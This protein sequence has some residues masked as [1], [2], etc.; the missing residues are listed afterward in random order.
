MPG[1]SAS[2]RPGW[3]LALPGGPH[4]AFTLIEMLVV[5]GILML[6]MGLTLG[7]MNTRRTD[8]LVAAEQL[9]AD[10]VRQGRHTARTSGAPVLL[11]IDQNERTIAG[12]MRTPAWGTT[13]DGGTSLGDN[14]DGYAGRGLMIETATDAL[15]EPI[16]ERQN[17]FG[18]PST[19]GFYL[20]CAVRPPTQGGGYLPL[21]TVTRDDSME[22]SIGGLLMRAVNPR[23]Q[24]YSLGNPN[25]QMQEDPNN[26][27]VSVGA[28]TIAQYELLGWLGDGTDEPLLVSNLDRATRPADLPDTTTESHITVPPDPLNPLSGWD[29]AQPLIGGQ[30][31]QVGLLFDGTQLI[32]FHNGRRVGT[33]INITGSFT[34]SADEFV[35]VGTLTIDSNPYLAGSTV[36]DNIRVDRLARSR[37]VG[38]PVGV[39][40]A[41]DVRILCLP[42]GRVEVSGPA[43]GTIELRDATSQ[44]RAV[45]TITTEGS[46]TTAI[47]DPSL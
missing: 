46:V 2:P 26:P 22:E 37:A 17:R 11:R 6:L 30:W 23:I 28:A 32:L 41:T 24:D 31:M 12:V 13:F 7:A 33:T 1:R 4:R 15:L 42:D 8:K 9:V 39:V 21:V 38:L 47:T 20:S 3:S 44:R 27:G 5:I 40:P 10:M 43:S 25:A 19:V 29:F 16:V 45:V 18:L 35:A 36:F 34:G 14:I